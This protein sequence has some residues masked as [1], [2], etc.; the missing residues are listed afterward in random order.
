MIWPTKPAGQART[1]VSSAFVTGHPST[2]AHTICWQELVS[3][4]AQT[5]PSSQARQR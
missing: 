3:S 1:A 5:P 4:S 2:A